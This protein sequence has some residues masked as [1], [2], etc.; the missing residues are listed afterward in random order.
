MA[1]ENNNSMELN[2]IQSSGRFGDI[3][4]KLNNNF[5]LIIEAILKKRDGKSAYE[6]WG[7]QPG[8]EG[9]TLNE[10]LASL[11]ESGFA[12][13]AVLSLPTGSEISENTIYAVPEKSDQELADP[14]M[15]AEYIR[16]GD[17][18]VLIARHDESGLGDLILSF[19]N[20]RIELNATK[21][22]VNRKAELKD[23]EEDGAFFANEDGE[24]F[25]KYTGDGLDAN[26]VSEHFKG[27][28]APDLS[29]YPTTEEVEDMIEESGQSEQSSLV[30][31]EEE[32]AFFCDENGKVFMKY[33]NANGLDVNKVSEHLKG[34]ITPS[35]TRKK[36]IAILKIPT[37]NS[38]VKTLEIPDVKFNQ[39]IG[40][41][42][43]IDT[44]GELMIYRVF[45]DTGNSKFQQSGSLIKIDSTTLYVYSGATKRTVD[46]ITT[47]DPNLIGEYEHG[48]NL[49]DFITVIVDVSSTSVQ[50]NAAV[51]IVTTAKIEIVTASSQGTVGT[52]VY[53]VS[54]DGFRGCRDNL[55]VQMNNGQMTDCELTWSSKDL[56]KDVWVF[57]DSYLDYWV[58]YAM[59]F[60]ANNAMYDGHS[61]RTSTGTQT[62]GGK[63][64]LIKA[65][66]IAD[67]PRI[68][69]WALGMN[70]KDGTTA[71]ATANANWQNAY[72]YVKNVCEEKGI[73]LILCTIP[74]IVPYPYY[75]SGKNAIIR[76]SGY[77]VIDI[78][79]AVGGEPS[80]QDWFTGY[81][82]N[83]TYNQNNQVTSY[84]IHPSA[85]GSQAIAMKI[86]QSIPSLIK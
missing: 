78:S 46:N 30:N 72:N 50:N 24:V 58:K 57:G 23:T 56:A 7:E 51:N 86:L 79:E 13:K 64:S 5:R 14:D 21:S 26:K 61:G 12:S 25:L 54:C 71:S 53:K 11:K 34:L 67:S 33:D 29:P 62:P 44:F 2:E 3:A 80:R 32:G 1:E 84:N 6:L 10:F 59:L 48:L 36:N 69:V 74:N 28:V 68:L 16:Q 73:N 75:N 55:C 31:T 43:K 76:A 4:A 15:W 37:L 60:G 83:D 22:S 49:S 65:L 45:P 38:T 77:Q 35:A 20:L 47:Y 81:R 41:S 66:S 82:G 42:G 85:L 18:W 39:C 63:E 9:K 8:N 19:R 52:S 17:S 40:F 70:D 27:L